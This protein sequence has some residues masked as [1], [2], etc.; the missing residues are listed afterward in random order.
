M[1]AERPP[2]DLLAEAQDHFGQAGAG[3]LGLVN[4]APRIVAGDSVASKA[5]VL[6]LPI[7][8]FDVVWVEGLG[9]PY[10]RCQMTLAE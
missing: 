4:N 8:T 10:V 3:R 5:S 6:G 7:V 9:I 2:L 1:F